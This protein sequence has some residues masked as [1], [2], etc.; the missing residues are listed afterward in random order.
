MIAH[1][2]LGNRPLQISRKLKMLI[3]AG[4]IT[5]GGNRKLKIYG[6]L[7]CKSGK[8]MKAAN[9]VFFSSEV[10]AVCAGYRPCG[11]CMKGEYRLW[12]AKA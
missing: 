1:Q 9:R 3:D 6:K 4:M 2:Q 8:R 7:N 12:K 10:E 11:H 5:L